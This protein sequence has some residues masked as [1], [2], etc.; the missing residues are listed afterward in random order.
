[1]G[2]PYL[3]AQVAGSQPGATIQLFGLRLRRTGA[4]YIAR[5]LLA[6]R[7]ISALKALVHIHR[8]ASFFQQKKNTIQFCL[9]QLDRL[10]I[11]SIVILPSAQH[12]SANF[13][14]LLSMFACQRLE[15]NTVSQRDTLLV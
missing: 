8:L 5:R 12:I 2:A 10:K 3:A 9:A 11:A 4:N 13:L 15:E 14:D 7:V 6:M 1:M